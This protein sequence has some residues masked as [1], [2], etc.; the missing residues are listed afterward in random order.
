MGGV[1]TRARLNKS[2]FEFDAVG[3]DARRWQAVPAGGVIRVTV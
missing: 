3:G 1:M 2:E